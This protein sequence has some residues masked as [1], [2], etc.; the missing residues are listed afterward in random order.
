M[1]R[2]RDRENQRQMQHNGADTVNIKYQEIRTDMLQ[3]Y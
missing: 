3:K 2:K 1:L